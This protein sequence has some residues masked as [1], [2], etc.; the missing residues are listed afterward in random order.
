M[1]IRLGLALVLALVALALFAPLLAPY[2]PAAQLDLETLRNVPPS[3]AHP[4]GTDPYSRDLLSRVLHGARLSLTIALLAVAL[5][6]T[7][8]TAIG[9][10]SGWAGGLAD[11]VLMRLVDAGLA[12]PKIFIVLVVL[13]LWEKVTV[14][15]LIAILGGTGWFGVSR[16]VRAEVRA[17]RD[18][19]YVAAARALGAS[20]RR[21]VLRHVLPNVAAPVIVIAAMGVGQVVL[22]EAG[23]AYLGVG[24]PQPTPSWG[25]IIADG[26]H[27]LLTAPWVAT[28]AGLAVVVTVLAFSLLGDGLREHLDPRTR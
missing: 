20:A 14:V 5:A 26:Q 7:V 24:V 18:R 12:V 23:L 21:V 3:V 19:E 2:P 28:S 8:G 17:A 10:A 4:F 27:L 25:N 11:T 9:L 16:I 15:A 22:L 6:V 1:R 13:A